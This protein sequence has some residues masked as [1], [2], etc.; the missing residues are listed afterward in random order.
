MNAPQSVSSPFDIARFPFV[1]TLVTAAWAFFNRVV[2]ELP[3]IWA[4]AFGA[5]GSLLLTALS[6]NLDSAVYPQQWRRFVI[7]FALGLF[8]A[9]VLAGAAL[10]GE[11][12]VDQ[13]ADAGDSGT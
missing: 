3:P 2:N 1:G 11:E 10:G 4:L 8:N 5:T 13:G 7:Y 12:V 6:P 9:I